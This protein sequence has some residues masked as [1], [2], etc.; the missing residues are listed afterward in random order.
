MP[1]KAQ[2]YKYIL[3]ALESAFS[4]SFLLNLTSL[5]N[6][7]LQQQK[8]SQIMFQ[9]MCKSGCGLRSS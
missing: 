9:V 6:N 3:I 1:W 8:K 4:S 5:T 2:R 7:T